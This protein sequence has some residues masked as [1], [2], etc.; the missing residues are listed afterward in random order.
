MVNA[1]KGMLMKPLNSCAIMQKKKFIPQLKLDY[2]ET[3]V[4]IAHK[5]KIFGT[6]PKKYWVYKMI[7]TRGKLH[8]T[9]K[10]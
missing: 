3:L 1:R 7:F 2:E 4:G 8:G 6:V 5:A 10:T 9:S